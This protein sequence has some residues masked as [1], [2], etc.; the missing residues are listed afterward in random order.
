MG[1]TPS[2]AALILGTV[3]TVTLVL[4][5]TPLVLAGVL[6][7]G[8]A[9][10]TIGA[11]PAGRAALEGVAY[12]PLIL[13][14]FRGTPPLETMHIEAATLTP[15]WCIAC[16]GNKADEV[17]LD[18]AYPTAHRVHLTS[19]LLILE[20][21]TCHQSV[22]LLQGSAA[23][24]RKQVDVELCATCHS[25][26]PSVMQSEWQNLDCTGCHANWQER[27]ARATLVN[28]DA[29]TAQDCLKCHGGAAWYQ[30]RR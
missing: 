20:C 6:G 13:K 18:P 27:M 11:A 2:K 12:L 28:L 15:A 25:P 8:P 29:I 30:E 14:G 9:P 4:I 24:L 5:L 23:S 10:W 22:D 19:A 7:T 17:S 1:K 16:H 21:T 3:V 26:F